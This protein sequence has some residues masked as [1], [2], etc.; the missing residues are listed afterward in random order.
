MYSNDSS[1][2]YT[3]IALFLQKK[4]NIIIT[5]SHTGWFACPWEDCVH[6][7][8]YCSGTCWVS[9]YIYRCIHKKNICLWLVW[10]WIFGHCLNAFPNW[11]ILFLLFIIRVRKVICQ[12]RKVNVLQLRNLNRDIVGQIKAYFI[13]WALQLQASS[14]PVTKEAKYTG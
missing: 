9:C 4:Q 3:R 1:K 6:L 11:E 10:P 5:S 14:P 8:K 13:A 7:L 12:V 2:R